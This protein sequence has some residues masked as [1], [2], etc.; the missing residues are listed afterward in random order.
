[1]WKEIR[2]ALRLLGKT[3]GFTALTLFVLAAGLGIAVYMYALVRTLAFADTPFPAHERLMAVGAVV[4]GTEGGGNSI[5]GFDFQQFAAE[6]K[7]FDVFIQARR[8]HVTLSGISLPKKLEAYYSTSQLFELTAVPALL[9]RFLQ[10]ADTAA[11]APM[12]AV[13]SH[14][15]WQRDFH[16]SRD[17]VGQIIKIDD[18]PVTVVGV[19]PAE[20]RFPE[21]AELWLPQQ[22]SKTLVP[23]EGP[24]AIIIGRLHDGVSRDQADAELKAIAKRLEQQHPATNTGDSVKVWPL[25]QQNMNNSMAIVAVMIAAASVILLLVVLNVGNLLLVRA[26]ERQKE[27]ALRAALGA[28][29]PIL[30]RQILWEALLL[31]LAGG[32]IGLFFAS[33]GLRWTSTE[34]ADVSEN[35]PFWWQFGI[36]SH[37]LLFAFAATV[38]TALAVG[39]YPAIRA[40]SGDMNRYLRDGTRGAQ[41]LRMTRMTH[42]LVIAEIALSIALLIASLT[43]VGSTR[44]IM[45]ADFG[46]RTG[47][48]LIGEID[49]FT[50]KYDLD[51]AEHRRFTE[52]IQQQLSRLPGVQAVSLGCHLPGMYG[53]IW[54]Y[55]VEGTEVPD[56]NYPSATR[57][58][59][60][61]NYFSTFEIPLIQGRLFDARDSEKT[62]RVAIISQSFAEKN[63]PG[64]VA[65]GKRIGLDRD[66][67]PNNEK[68]YTVIGVVGDAVYGQPYVEVSRYSDLYLTLRQHPVE[69]L[70]VAVATEGEP[71]ALARALATEVARADADIPVYDMLSLEERIYR[72]NAGMVFVSK[73]FLVMAGLGV[74]LAAS[75]IYGVIARSV[76]LRT[77]ELGV[78]RALGASEERVLFMLFKQAGIRFAVGAAVGLSLALLMMKALASVLYGMEGQEASIAVA[79]LLLVGA[80]VAT[81]TVL[82]ARY[83]VRLSPAAALRYE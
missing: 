40:S 33:W 34:W 43:L 27:I 44:N 79:V 28:P 77:Q 73:L 5:S 61:D 52:Q 66:H 62:E 9:G 25:T 83:A 47:N 15:V 23:G 81:A 37:N 20:Y 75:G 53:P 18:E 7:S 38:L 35:L 3:P 67:D 65:V 16:A 60:S 80:I 49:L 11:G 24:Y 54:T 12:V 57:V 41:S 55:L 10:P 46:A 4:D 29:R 32:V 22:V 26:A 8:S 64:Q 19:M 48:I 63:W 76:V 74:L 50:Q 68:W 71:L 58:I 45:Q 1:M 72:Y 51:P 13:L 42:V 36:D 14:K 31:A 2:Y 70:V 6:Q 59:I 69:D 21:T 39:L 78:R 17:V 56:K 30:I 82:P